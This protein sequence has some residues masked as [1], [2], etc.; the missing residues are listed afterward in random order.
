M[1]VIVGN[2]NI[3]KLN[4]KDA[5]EENLK[6]L[7]MLKNINKNK[8]IKIYSIIKNENIPKIL[9]KIACQIIGP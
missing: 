2:T 6:I 7:K 8:K 1:F 3:N 4:N 5:D 9:Y